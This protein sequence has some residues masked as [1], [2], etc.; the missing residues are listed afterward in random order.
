L[1]CPVDPI[2]AAG[3][4]L[5]VFNVVRDPRDVV[6]SMIAFGDR[7]GPRGF[8]RTPGE[9]DD[10]WIAGL[11]RTFATRLDMMLAPSAGSILLRYEDFAV[12]LHAT[13]DLLGQMLDVHLDADAALAQRP[14]NHV[15][16]TSV[17]ESLG[18]WRRDLAP[19]LADAIW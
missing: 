5:R 12:N 1:A 11:M 7:S 6:A 4:P 14:E 2:I 18:R 9:T 8:G 10:E 19:G 16:T 13:A 17:E 15:T 3:I